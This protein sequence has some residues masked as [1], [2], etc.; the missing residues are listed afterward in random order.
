MAGWKYVGM[1]DLGENFQGLD[2]AGAGAV[3]ELMT[4]GEKRPILTYCPQPGPRIVLGK[5]G[6]FMSGA[7]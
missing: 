6:R 2:Q 7:L 1:D 4:I 5:H 3:E